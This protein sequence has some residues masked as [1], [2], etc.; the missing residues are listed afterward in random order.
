MHKKFPITKNQLNRILSATDYRTLINDEIFSFKI[1][2]LPK[3]L[4][5]LV[6]REWNMLKTAKKFMIRIEHKMH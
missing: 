1:E 3:L 4:I 2:I 5:F 6:L